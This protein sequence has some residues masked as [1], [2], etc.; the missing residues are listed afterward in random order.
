MPPVEQN[1]SR[2]RH[3]VFNPLVS[4]LKFERSGPKLDV[5]T[6]AA[7]VGSRKE[8]HGKACLWLHWNEL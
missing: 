6:K 3:P 5:G 1:H 2:V 7:G 4:R 8:Q